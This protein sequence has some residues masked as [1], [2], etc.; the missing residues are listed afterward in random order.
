MSGSQC[1][2][3]EVPGAGATHAMAVA[4]LTDFRSEDLS[5][6]PRDCTFTWVDEKARKLLSEGQR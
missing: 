1:E 4:A 6:G 5:K 2:N 3:G